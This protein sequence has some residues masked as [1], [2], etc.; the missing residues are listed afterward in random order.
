MNIIIDG[1]NAL[2]KKGSS[3]EYISE[4]RMFT[5]SDGY[6]YSLTFP[7]KGCSANLN[8]FGHL[9]RL[10]AD[11]SNISFQCQI[12][13]TYFSLS[14][15]L[16]ITDI[17][18]VEVK[19]QILT[20][21]S[22]ENYN[23]SFDNVY[24]N[25]LDLGEPEIIDHTKITPT[26]AWSIG[27]SGRE[28]VA[29]P[30]VNNSSDSL[31]MQNDAIYENGGY[32]WAENVTGLSWQPYLIDIT[33]RICLAL[34][35]EVDFDEWGSHPTYR[36][37]LICNTLPY[38]WD[39][40]EY[41]KALPHWSVAEFFDQLELVLGCEFTWDHY[42]KNVTMKFTSRI[43]DK[44][45]NVNI[46][47]VIDS[48]STSVDINNIP[49]YLPVSNIKY[50]ESG[51]SMEKYYSCDWFI[52]YMKFHS[53]NKHPRVLTYDTLQ[54][55]IAEVK[56]YM[57][58]KIQLSDFN[59]NEPLFDT[60]ELIKLA[61]NKLF[62]V[63]DVDT[64]FILR[65]Y[66]TWTGIETI[67]PSE[68]EITYRYI[69]C[70]L[71]PINQFAPL[72]HKKDENTPEI[73][74]AMIPVAIDETDV[75]EKGFTMFLTPGEAG[76]TYDTTVDFL[77]TNYPLQIISQG[78]IEKP[79]G[80]YDTIYLAFWRGSYIEGKLPVPL[81]DSMTYNLNWEQTAHSGC[82]LRLKDITMIASIPNDYKN[83]DVSKKYEI[84]FLM[85]EVPDVR[86][87]FYINGKKFVCEKITTTFSE[88]GMSELKKGVFYRIID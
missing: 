82:S 4:N 7:L 25:N 19:G 32:N 12:L 74:L 29:L 2:L 10:D 58:I 55:F 67:T 26:E 63:I 76:S 18:D 24:I 83:I 42:K 17:S 41:A 75:K 59:P 8:I 62:Y 14:G 61:Y 1:K 71:Q 47:N 38:A 66:E 20:D 68:F 78:N 85:D 3:F 44:I 86:A 13:D 31:N 39:M 73:E 6:S 22:I 88:N 34:G 49:E 60:Y 79:E 56:D 64:Y 50:K 11:F 87:I 69:N 16:I 23:N 45:P 21:R 33:Y 51:H 27:I 48:F 53:T 30:W 84:S 57:P 35:Y 46:L 43:L 81:I 40:P 77:S 15:I 80:F 28:A 54:R 65:P 36:Y 9:N 5:S 52:E 72:I 37:L 70:Y